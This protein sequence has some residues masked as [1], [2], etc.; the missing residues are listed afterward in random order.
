MTWVIKDNDKFNSQLSLKEALYD[1]QAQH[2]VYKN[3]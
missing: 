3:I 1:E 2:I